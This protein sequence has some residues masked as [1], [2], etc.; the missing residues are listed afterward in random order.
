MNCVNCGT[1]LIEGNNT[2][3]SCGALNMPLNTPPTPEPAPQEETLET[4]ETIDNTPTENQVSA[5]TEAPTLDVQEEVLEAEATEI[6]DTASQPTYE[7]EQPQE[8]V[9]EQPQVQQQD[10]VNLN[11]PSAAD[12]QPVAV[13]QNVEAGGVGTVDAPTQTAG[14]DDIVVPEKG[15]TKFKI[16]KKEFKVKLGGIKITHIAIYVC[17]VCLGLFMGYLMFGNRTTTKCKKQNVKLTQFVANGKNNTTLV[18]NYKYT[19]PNNY[20]YDKSND[21]VIIYDQDQTFKIFIKN[22]VFQYNKLVNAKLSIQQSFIDSGIAVNDIKELAVNEKSYLVI[23]A[24]Q[25]MHNRM[26]GITDAGNG[27][28]FYAEILTTDNTFNNEYLKI[29]DD[30]ITNAEKVS[31]VPSIEKLKI[32]DLS[33]LTITIGERDDGIKRENSNN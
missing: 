17:L 28:I 20:N 3:P 29:A 22:V 10:N 32:A 11:I 16:G 4:V 13:D 18:N 30:I 24:T 6:A 15:V 7:P 14:Q 12:I 8:Q 21:G 27:Q 25:N 1:P 26:I 33:Q 9:Q 23:N 2:C 5:A 19:I 31:D